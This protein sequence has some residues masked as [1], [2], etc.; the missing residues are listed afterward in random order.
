MF[1]FTTPVEARQRTDVSPVT[2]A[3]RTASAETGVSFDYLLATARRE[4]ALMP[5]AQAKTSSARGLFQF[6]EQTWL[7]MV[8]A[9]GADVGLAAEAQAIRGRAGRLDVADGAERQRILS[10]RNDPKLAASLAAELTRENSDGLSKV[11]GRA[12]THGELYIAHFL[13][14]GGATRLIQGAQTSPEASAAVTFPAAAKANRSIFYGKDGSPRS[15]GA[16]YARLV[17]GFEQNTAGVQ[18]ALPAVADAPG[19]NPFH[20]LFRT[21]TTAPVSRAVAAHFLPVADRTDG[22]GAPL[23]ITPPV[24][25][26]QKRSRG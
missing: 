17:A 20:R 21:G 5:Q 7:R 22:P 12:P 6:V 4:S 1:L 24:S 18:P 3:L 9:K 26:F 13:G 15:L 16:V 23:D 8:Q 25:F 11:L 10:L 2:G 19:S 14:L